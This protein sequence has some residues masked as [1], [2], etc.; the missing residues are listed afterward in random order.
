VIIDSAPQIPRFHNRYYEIPRNP[1]SAF[2]ERNDVYMGL[3]EACLPSNGPDSPPQQ[4]RFVLY[5][6]GGSGKTQLCLKFAEEHR[7]KCV[8]RARAMTLL[9]I[10]D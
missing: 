1:S 8:N 2:T 9:R 4:R 5:G 3:Q 10:R 6:L 7:E